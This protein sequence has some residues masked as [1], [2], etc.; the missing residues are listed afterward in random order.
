M[1]N[2]PDVTLFVAEILHS[3]ALLSSGDPPGGWVGGG[4]GK[5]GING[6]GAH[7][8]VVRARVLRH[9]FEA[10][11]WAGLLKNGQVVLS[12]TLISQCTFTTPQRLARA[13]GE[14]V[15]TITA[16]DTVYTSA[17]AD[18]TIKRKVLLAR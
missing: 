4:L 16:M 5:E 18:P 8:A 9:L 3:E 10:G 1:L 12:W 14:G 6:A 2:S 7:P 11:H 15:G 13:W 17:A